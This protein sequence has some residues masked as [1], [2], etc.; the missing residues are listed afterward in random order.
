MNLT[1]EAHDFYEITLPAAG[2][3]KVRFNA[4]WS[5]YSEDFDDTEVIAVEGRAGQIGHPAPVGGLA[6]PPCAFII[7]SQD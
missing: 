1:A 4:D 6:L 7:L 2:E 5:G 3:W